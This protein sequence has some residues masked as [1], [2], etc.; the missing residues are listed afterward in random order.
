MNIELSDLELA[1]TLLAVSQ[2]AKQREEE[3]ASLP[4]EEQAN[5]AAELKQFES[6][7]EKLFS[8]KYK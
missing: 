4:E 1:L 7:R 6:L 2:T 5:A 3:M 8:A